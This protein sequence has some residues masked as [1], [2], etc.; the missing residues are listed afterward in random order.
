M[1]STLFLYISLPLFCT[2]T[3]WNFQKLL[4]YT[5]YGGNVVRVLVHF[6]FT[7]AHFHLALVAA[8]ISHFVTAATKFSHVVLP[9]TKCLLLSK[10]NT[11]DNTDTETFSAFRFR[12]HWAL[13]VCALQ[14]GGRYAISRQNKLELHLGCHTCWVSSFTLVCLWCGRLLLFAD[15]PEKNSNQKQAIQTLLELVC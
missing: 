10:L 14:D 3:T 1:C 9:I 6:F 13:V 7:A 11:L 15:W 8:S 2:T 4:S 12:L 5:F